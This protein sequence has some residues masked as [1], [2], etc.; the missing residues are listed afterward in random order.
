MPP[1][2]RR[3]GPGVRHPHMNTFTSL[4]RLRSRP[5]QACG[6]LCTDGTLAD[7]AARGTNPFHQIMH[8]PKNHCNPFYHHFC[9]E[10]PK[11]GRYPCSTASNVALPTPARN[12]Q[13]QAPMQ[14]ALH[15][16]ARQTRRPGTSSTRS[17][18][19]S[20]KSVCTVSAVVKGALRPPATHLSFSGGCGAVAE[21]NLV[22]AEGRAA[23][24]RVLEAN[25]RAMLGS[26]DARSHG[27]T[28]RDAPAK[29]DTAGSASLVARPPLHTSTQPSRFGVL[30]WLCCARSS[31]AP[32]QVHQCNM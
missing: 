26:R 10:L 15:A 24:A 22:Q 31:D 6:M 9:Q 12:K 13:L 18:A 27:Q 16:T 23:A 20:V 21:H 28:I 30:S 19:Q 32:P 25:L 29:W 1:P 4:R 5:G 8:R 11:H 3:A 7:A 17:A 14:S 2:S